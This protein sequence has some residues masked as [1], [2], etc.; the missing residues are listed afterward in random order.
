MRDAIRSVARRPGESFLVALAVALGVGLPAVMFS[1]VYGLFLRP[2]PFDDSGT[3]LQISG[4]SGEMGRTRLAL[5]RREFELLSHGASSFEDVVAWSGTS[6][7]ASGSEA[8]A[9][10]HNGAVITENFLATLGVQPILGGGFYGGESSVAEQPQA[11]ISHRVWR[12]RYAGDPRILGR[13]IRLNGQPTSVVGVMPEGFLF[14]VHQDFWFPMRRG[15]SANL[16]WDRP[17]LQVF[18][19]LADGVG[20]EVAQLELGGLAAGLA[21][22][23]PESDGGFG[24]LARPYVEAY[25]DPDMRSYLMRMLLAVCG[26]FLIACA[27]VTN[28]MV[29]RTADRRRAIGIRRALG[30]RPL[31]IARQLF[32]EVLVLCGLG[33][34]LGIAAAAAVSSRV[35]GIIKPVLKS[36]WVDVRLDGSV[37]LFCVSLTVL[38][39]LLSSLLPA[40]LTARVHPIQNIRNGDR[41]GLESAAH[42]WRAWLVSLQVALSCVLLIG[43][44][45]LVKSLLQLESTDLGFS[46]D[47]L[48]TARISLP[49]SD[50]PDADSWRGFYSRLQQR[51]E[52]V[53]GIQ[54]VTFTSSIP[55]GG[56]PQVEIEIEGVPSANGAGRHSA[57][58]VASPGFF[59]TFGVEVLS[60]RGFQPTDD[61][62]T[63]PVAV[64]SQSFVEA[65]LGGVEPLG[66]TLGFPGSDLPN[67]TIVGTVTDT[68]KNTLPRRPRGFLPALEAPAGDADD[69][70][71]YLPLAQR[72]RR[73]LT[74]ALRSERPAGLLAADIKRQVA[75]LDSDLVTFSIESYGDTLASIYWDYRLSSRLFVGFGIAGLCL[76]M[77]GLYSTLSLA[78]EGRTREI[79]IR[80]ALGSRAVEVLRMVLGQGLRTLLA[81]VAAGV[82]VGFLLARS[83]NALLFAV[84]PWDLSVF[85]VAPV[86]LLATGVLACLVPAIRAMRVEPLAALREES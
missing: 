31:A 75:E 80:I 85:L 16:D 11:L 32:S 50:Y 81:G 64:V 20:L 6:V 76:A 73:W 17:S 25:S 34:L 61:G 58:V 48:I 13:E 57:T 86:A 10:H 4:K 22:T 2:L 83:L 41:G 14:P 69:G 19:R 66:R 71:V 28:L 78:V 52:T 54:D 68:F 60:G 27:N 63:G 55:V 5:S 67:V 62:T 7:V 18:G 65:H 70:I 46:T 24:F 23:L 15:G 33:G 21:R 51:L 82:G 40:I 37:V 49:A 36:F 39:A 38:C 35:H 79:G 53:P 26:V 3:L 56:T 77:I 30:A 1:L 12:D 74:L 44:G 84:E 45:L 47:D 29:N 43:T 8:V 59:E 9:S 72:P 42:R